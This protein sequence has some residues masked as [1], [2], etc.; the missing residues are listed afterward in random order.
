MSQPT[1]QNHEK[2]K[3]WSEWMA[4]AQV[5]DRFAYEKLMTE[6]G[7]A[8]ERFVRHR[9]GRGAA[10]DLVE[11][12]VQ[13]SLLAI[14]RARH[15]YDP[16]R[17]FRPWFLT[18]VRHKAIDILRRDGVRHDKFSPMPDPLPLEA[19]AI[20]PSF[21]MDATTVLARLKPE[22]RRALILTKLEG[23]S[24]EE[25]ARQEGVSLSA[26]K[27]RVHRAIRTV[28]KHFLEQELD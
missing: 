14:H 28:Q 24:L 16:A 18:I 19:P 20:D 10:G 2:E 9:F 26:M 11:E 3:R 4:H 25:A 13:E 21:Q 15:T 17:S 1:P 6:L 12:C 7:R 23:C 27:T 22:Y 5:G 8:I